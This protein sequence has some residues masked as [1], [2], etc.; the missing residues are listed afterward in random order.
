MKPI[1]F[2]EI[3]GITKKKSEKLEMLISNFGESIVFSSK[4]E[5]L[6]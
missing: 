3:K 1:N 2:I 4:D 5:L 6:I